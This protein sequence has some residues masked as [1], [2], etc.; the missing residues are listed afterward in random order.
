MN[1]PATTA[2]PSP[3]G[4]GDQYAYLQLLAKVKEALD[5]ATNI[6]VPAS[7]IRPYP[8][9]PRTYF[10]EDGIRRLSE[11]IDAGGQTTPGLIRENPGS[12]P[13]ELIDGERR[14]RAVSRIP[15]ERRPEYK[16]LLIRADDEVVQFL[17][18]GTANF[19]RE[20]H[21]ALE[22]T[23]TI[24][25]LVGFGLPMKEIASLLGI[26]EHWAYQMHG[27]KKLAPEVSAML[28]PDLPRERQLPVSAAIQISKIEPRLQRGIADRVLSKDISLGRLRG[29]V[30]R[31]A[32]RAGS[33][34]RTRE[35]SPLKRWESFGKRIEQ[36]ARSLGDANHVVSDRSIDRI[37]DAHPKETA[38]ALRNLREAKKAIEEIEAAIQRAQK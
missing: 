35:V 2:S 14:W 19:N 3:E 15:E 18:S 21:T 1:M 9:Q 29:E 8:N 10:S 38:R 12:T 16:A 37:V 33:A 26:S 11:A 30:V 22:V 5:S 13:Y 36:G 24:D 28:D 27:L 17:I 25:R 7:D 34:I 20:N 6:S 32:Q 23:E 4:A 31:V